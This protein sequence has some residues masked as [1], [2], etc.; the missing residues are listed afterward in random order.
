MWDENLDKIR[1]IKKYPEKIKTNYKPID[2]LLHSES[3]KFS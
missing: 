3:I 2:P 1:C